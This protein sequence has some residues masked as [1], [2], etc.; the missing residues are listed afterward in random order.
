MPDEGKGMGEKGL[1]P[2]EPPRKPEPLKEGYAPPPSPKEPP[3]EPP[4]KK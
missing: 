4:P 2:P 3:T 1:V